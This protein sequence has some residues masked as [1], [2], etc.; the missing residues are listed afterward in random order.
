MVLGHK[1]AD[2]DHQTMLTMMSATGGTRTPR[3]ASANNIISQYA[4]TYQRKQ[5]AV[6][7]AEAWTVL[8]KL[9]QRPEYRTKELKEL[10][11]SSK[12]TDD[13]QNIKSGTYYPNLYS[14]GSATTWCLDLNSTP[15]TKQ[16]HY[17]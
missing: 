10:W 14:S 5:F 3:V 2:R 12:R 7:A 6:K 8:T 9:A 16:N 11:P 17:S 15:G 13:L 1:Y 4:R